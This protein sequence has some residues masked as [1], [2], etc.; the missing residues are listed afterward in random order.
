MVLCYGSPSKVIQ[1]K[2]KKGRR[3]GREKK[4]EKRKKKKV[5]EGEGAGRR[6]GREGEGREKKISV[7]SDSKSCLK[8]QRK[9]IIC[10]SLSSPGKVIK[11][12]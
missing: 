3:G 4:K 7:I 9:I 8:E 10:G 12:I 5:G 2:R 6:E 11:L 1:K